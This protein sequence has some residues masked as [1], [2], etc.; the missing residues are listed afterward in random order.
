MTSWSFNEILRG[1]MPKLKEHDLIGD[2]LYPI[3]KYCTKE[4]PFHVVSDVRNEVTRYLETRNF[5]VH[6]IS[7][8]LSM[9]PITAFDTKIVRIPY[10]STLIDQRQLRPLTHIQQLSAESADIFYKNAIDNYIK[11]FEQAECLNILQYFSQYEKCA[12]NYNGS[13][14]TYL[15]NDGNKWK[16]LNKHRVVRV[17]PYYEP[18]YG[19]LYFKQLIMCYSTYRN[20]NSLLVSI[21]DFRQ[22]CADH[23]QG[24]IT[25]NENIRRIDGDNIEIFNDV[26]ISLTTEIRAMYNLHVSNNNFLPISQ[27][28]RHQYYAYNRILNSNDKLF[29]IQRGPGTGTSNFSSIKK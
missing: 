5:T 22:F 10:C 21:D 12:R 20:V 17:Y 8:L 6:E 26:D 9:Q 19:D 28:S 16:K 27:F 25:L 13:S 3:T 29:I 18:S 24:V 1:E 14:P 4:E 11:R 2:Y 23:F 7:H 15:D